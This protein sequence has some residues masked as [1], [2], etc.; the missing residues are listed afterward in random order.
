MLATTLAVGGAPLPLPGLV[1]GVVLALGAAASSGRAPAL[2]A[3][4]LAVVAAPAWLSGAGVVVTPA[5][6][7]PGLSAAL[8]QA[9]ALLLAILAPA[10]WPAGL[11]GL[12]VGLGLIL[13]LRAALVAPLLPLAPVLAAPLVVGAVV[14]AG[15]ASLP[16]GGQRGPA[17]ALIMVLLVRVGFSSGPWVRPPDSPAAVARAAAS[18][19]LVRQA[20]ALAARPGLGLYALTLQPSAHPVALALI[21]GLGVE[22]PLD[23]GWRPEGAAL[24]PALAMD[25]ALSLDRRGRGGEALRLSWAGRADPAVAWLWL[26]LARDQGLVSSR[27]AAPAAPATSPPPLAPRLPGRVPLGWAFLTAGGAQV[28]LHLDAPMDALVLEVRGQGW[29]GP[30]VLTLQVDAEAPREVILPEGEGQLSLPGPWA[31]GPHRLRARFDNDAA[32]VDGDR[33][34]W[35]DALRGG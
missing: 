31:A 4:L 14:V 25:L 13:G 8:I 27:Q 6:P 18:G 16:A 2:S 34:A 11:R 30:A 15:A 12:I 1:L 28:D 17:A 24:S 26:L 35:V 32:G 33:N 9:L 22:A 7:V 21:P 29:R 10:A 5:A 20:P 3:G 23:A 19:A